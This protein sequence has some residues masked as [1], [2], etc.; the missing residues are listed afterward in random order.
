[1]QLFRSVPKSVPMDLLWPK[2][3][4]QL[5]D[6]TGAVVRNRTADLLIT[7]QLLYQLSYNGNDAKYILAIT[8]G[9]ISSGPITCASNYKCPLNC[10]S[11]LLRVSYSRFHYRRVVC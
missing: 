1:M 2:I 10:Q 3:K 7:N 8:K 4:L 5:I 9:A 11:V 6:F